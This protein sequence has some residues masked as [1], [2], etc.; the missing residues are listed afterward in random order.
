[1]KLG[2]DT[3]NTS[4]SK[5]FLQGFELLASCDSLKCQISMFSFDF[6]TGTLMKIVIFIV[7]IVHGS[8]VV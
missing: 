7:I 5:L 1:M 8:V 2:A 6:N 3:L 4:S